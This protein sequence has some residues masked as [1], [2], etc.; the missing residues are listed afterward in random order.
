MTH[1][2]DSRSRLTSATHVCDSHSRLVLGTHFRDSRSRLPIALPTATRYFLL[3]LP[4]CGSTT[5]GQTVLTPQHHLPSVPTLT[6]TTTT[7]NI[8]NLPG[9]ASNF[10]YYPPS[11]PPPLVALCLLTHTQAHYLLQ[12]PPP[13]PPP[14]PRQDPCK[15][16]HLYH[17]L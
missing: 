10:S 17:P 15:H 5:D 8:W 9:L 16:P 2:S 3:R 4:S 7:K 12:R 14:P 6:L 13:P 1:I 11:C